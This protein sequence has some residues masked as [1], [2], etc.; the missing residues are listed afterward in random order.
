MGAEL[1]KAGG[2]LGSIVKTEA[3]TVLGSNP[4]ASARAFNVADEVSVMDG[5][6]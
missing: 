5:G 6:E 2:V 4:A 3:V 1:V